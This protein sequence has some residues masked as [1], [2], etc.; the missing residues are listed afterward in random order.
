[1]QTGNSCHFDLPGR[2]VAAQLVRVH[3]LSISTLYL[4]RIQTYRGHAVLIFDARHVTRMDELDEAEWR[5]LAA[6]LRI[7][8]QAV[9]RAFMPDHINVASIG[10][11]V[12]HLH[13]HIIPRY[14][15]D[16]RWGGPI[17]MTTPE[18]MPVVRLADSEYAELAE[19]LRA[20]LL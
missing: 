15:N 4:E 14:R 5:S 8:E 9:Y 13:W 18:E 10:Q 2:D 1:M 17:W 16:P 12:P 6:D 7:A 20:H 19:Q 11:V 3:A